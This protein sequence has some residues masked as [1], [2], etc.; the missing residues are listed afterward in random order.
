[1]FK[2]VGGN[3]RK[4]SLLERTPNQNTISDLTI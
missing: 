1:M 2:S 3:N 4:D